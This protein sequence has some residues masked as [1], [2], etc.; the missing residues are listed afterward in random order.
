VWRELIQRFPPKRILE[1]GSY[2]GRSTCFLIEE[3]A[4]LIELVCV[5]TWQGGSDQDKTVMPAVERR[6]DANVALS[7]AR[8]QPPI[9]FRK[10]KA[11]SSRACAAMIMS[12]EKFDLI[13]VDGSHEAPDVLIDAVNAFQL[14][15]VGGILIFDDYIWRT[16]VSGGKDV[17]NLPK[18]AIDAFVNIFHR[19]L[20]V[21]EAPLYQL[22]MRKIAE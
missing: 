18:I 9:T 21:F 6:F 17:L 14:L 15:S 13:Y 1:I 20:V 2:E 8:R 19:K 22:Y 10:C 11:Y 16:D 4:S 12:G 3:C 5:D 7:L